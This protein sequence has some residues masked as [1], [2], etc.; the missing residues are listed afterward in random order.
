MQ[1]ELKGGT[2]RSIPQKPRKSRTP[3]LSRDPPTLDI[4]AISAI[5]FHFNMYQKDNKVFMTSLYKIDRIINE[6]EEEPAKESNE[7]LVKR[8]LPT[9]LLSYRDA[10]SKAASD[11]LPP[12]RTY[13]YKI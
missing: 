8:L 12:Y 11:I 1:Q 9:Y 3:L 10:F 13:D 2:R 7:E 4:A 5:G 6:K